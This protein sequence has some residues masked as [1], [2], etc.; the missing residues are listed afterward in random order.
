MLLAIGAASFFAIMFFIVAAPKLGLLS[1]GFLG[2]F[3][4]SFIL[5]HKD[6]KN[7]SRFLL[8]SSGITMLF[9][10]ALLTGKEANFQLI[11]IVAAC[12]LFAFYRM[13][14]WRY[15]VS[16]LAVS[17]AGIV[18]LEITNYELLGPP[19]IDA[20]ALAILNYANFSFT[21][22]LTVL[23]CFNMQLNN[24]RILSFVNREKTKSQSIL[25]NTENA[26]WLID[27]QLETQTFNQ[28]C[29]DLLKKL[30]N[31][32]PEVGLPFDELTEQAKTSR[33]WWKEQLKKCVG[34]QRLFEQ[35]SVEYEG[36]AHHFKVSFNPVVNKEKVLGASIFLEDVTDAQLASEKI[37]EAANIEKDRNWIHAGIAEVTNGMLKNK[38]DKKAMLQVFINANIGYV[39]G[40]M[41]TLYLFDT[42]RQ[43]LSFQAGYAFQQKHLEKGEITPG[44]GM[45]GQVAIDK[46]PVEINDLSDDYFFVESSLGK[47]SPA[48]LLI[49]PLLFNDELIGV[50][51]IAKIT[52]FST[53]EKK[54]LEEVCL[55]AAGL[56]EQVAKRERAESLL[57]ETRELNS[58]LQVQE[59]EL[60]VNNEE[61]M[62]KTQEL[63][64]SEEE[65]KEQQE[66]LIQTNAQI[67]GKSKELEAQSDVLK[68]QNQVLEETRLVLDEK[69]KE[70]EAN[71]QYK[72]E[73]L[74]NMSHELR[75]PLNSIMI[76][77][78][79][80]SENEDKPLSGKL[81][82]YT[83]VIGKSGA[84]LLQLIN[85]IL[86]ISKIESRKLDIIMEDVSLNEFKND[87][88]AL[89]GEVAKDKGIQFKVALDPALPDVITSDR[90]R[91]AQII[92]NLLSNALKFTPENGTVTLGMLPP[93]GHENLLKEAG[94]THA[95]NRVMFSVTDTG[96]GIPEEKK[97][98]IFEAFSQMDGSIN[99]KYGGTGLGLTI[100]RQLANMLGGS[101]HL[102]SEVDKGSTF[103][104][105]LPI[106]GNGDEKSQTNIE[107]IANPN[108]KT[109]QPTQPKKAGTQS[110][111][112]IEDDSTLSQII[113]RQ[114]LENGFKCL[115]AKT[116]EEG[117]KKAEKEIPDAI[118]LDIRLPG[119]DGWE[120]IDQLK[121]N[122]LTAHIPVHMMSGN[123]SEQQSLEAGAKTFLQKPFNV[124]ELSSVFNS[125][126]IS[127][128]PVDH[129]VLLVSK[130]L[131][132]NRIASH[133]GKPNLE[134]IQVDEIS[135]VIEQLVM[136]KI[137][138]LVFNYAKGDDEAAVL[139]N[140]IS[141]NPE[142]AQIHI[143]TVLNEDVPPEEVNQ[144]ESSHAT[145]IVKGEK[146]YDRLLDETSLFFK[147]LN[148][149]P[150]AKPDN[151]E[152]LIRELNTG[153]I[154]GKTILIVDDDTR[155]IYSLQAALDNTNAILLTA[156]NG[157]E[158][159]E[160][161]KAHPEIDIVLM[162]I[163]MP[164]MDG[165]E[166]MGIIR[167]EMQLTQLPII[168]VT[169]KAMSTDA[170]KCLDA[171][172]SDYLPKPLDTGKLIQLMKVWIHKTDKTAAA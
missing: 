7:V 102:E 152:V 2:V 114:A 111:L 125:V 155:N 12:S 60:R 169:A 164:E 42:K 24:K 62:A 142:W 10:F 18:I 67:E 87:M 147:G 71:S 121:S 41:A 107:P 28:A 23:L 8:L 40:S 69:A 1:L 98:L 68:N 138:L 115:L 19:N 135:Q 109:F 104:L 139:I 29:A 170:E 22:V 54:L 146:Q 47:A 137:A 172:A 74:A 113:Q 159:I 88:E 158:A 112:I 157:I 124:E 120:V 162:D 95:D 127:N 99:R 134:V 51:E 31:R 110:L 75:T 72:S 165:Y 70:L 9:T 153:E 105:L 79:L 25:D 78:K 57:A 77:S 64:A 150:N 21:V 156:G 17:A 27:A 128:L 161:I 85:D 73:F 100:S 59:E 132:P 34:G 11:L 160:K 86:D 61:L 46:E 58:K 129:K 154:E 136:E 168:A 30:F 38:Q 26:I 44:Q 82:D 92:K 3:L 90:F 33:D 20:G 167:N 103:S 89:F 15:I 118:L 56:I 149:K 35:L 133:F 119:I 32:V 83:K 13:R 106:T 145:M 48:S 144:F 43:R 130:G 101:V 45:I 166:A 163:M 81:L 140:Q 123:S 143:I 93:N 63:I 122:E 97:Q 52:H 36:K 5:N 94:L 151:N 126:S 14:E 4:L 65:L 53:I 55:R 108:H 116:G 49:L 141:S 50:F 171:G 76:L 80:L 148:S 6:K 66:E 37:Q 131:D 16:F 96:I 84:D 39:K 117:I 91:L